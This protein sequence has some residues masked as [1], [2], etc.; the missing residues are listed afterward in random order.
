[1]ASA[2]VTLYDEVL[3]LFTLRI[4]NVGELRSVA[5]ALQERHFTSVRSADDKDPKMANAI[6]MLFDF[7][8]IE[9]NSL[10]HSFDARGVVRHHL[11]TR[12]VV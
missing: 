2:S 7:S 3:D 12:G 9:T 5:D 4:I 11:C 10:G 1:M 6:E 8:R